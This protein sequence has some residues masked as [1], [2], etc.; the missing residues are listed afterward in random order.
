MSLC[1][2]FAESPTCPQGIATFSTLFLRKC[3]W[4]WIDMESRGTAMSLSNKILKTY[5]SWL[6]KALLFSLESFQFAG[7]GSQLVSIAHRTS[8]SGIKGEHTPFLTATPATQASAVPA[9]WLPCPYGSALPLDA[10]LAARKCEKLAKQCCCVLLLSFL[11]SKLPQAL[12]FN[13]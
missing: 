7:R 6:L 12:S 4:W 8:T 5:S 3:G 10:A 2:K 11:I 1:I 13:K 9:S